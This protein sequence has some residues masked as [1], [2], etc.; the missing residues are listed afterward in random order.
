MVEGVS[1]IHE[2]YIAVSACNRVLVEC[3]PAVEGDMAVERGV[4]IVAVGHIFGGCVHLYRHVVEV[5][6]PCYVGIMA[7]EAVGGGPVIFPCRR[8]IEY[9]G[10]VAGGVIL[11]CHPHLRVGIIGC[12]GDV[13]L[14]FGQGDILLVGASCG[15]ACRSED[16][17][18][19]TV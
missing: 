1:D 13:G 9:V 8:D 16:K 10:T 19:G 5:L 12:D 18:E 3:R 17:N 15:K 6:L 14:L 2:G 11:I 7:D 4:E